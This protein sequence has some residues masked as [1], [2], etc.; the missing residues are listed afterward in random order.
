MRGR[1]LVLI[2]EQQDGL[3]DTRDL[4]SMPPAG[5]LT[6]PWRAEALI[7]TAGIFSFTCADTGWGELDRN[8]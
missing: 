3:G 4:V 5:S 7:G 6:Y 1:I 2:P 8:S